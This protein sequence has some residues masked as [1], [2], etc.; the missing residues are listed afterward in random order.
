MPLYIAKIALFRVF[1]KNIL[2]KKIG[3]VGHVDGYE[4]YSFG[5][6]DTPVGN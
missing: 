4:D 6:G 3:E 2:H 1:T 5:P